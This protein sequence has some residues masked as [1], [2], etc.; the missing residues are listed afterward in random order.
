MAEQLPVLVPFVRVAGR[1]EGRG[2]CTVSV[3]F[4]AF[5]DI[6]RYT[7]ILECRLQ[8]AAHLR[9]GDVRQASLV[10]A[11]EGDGRLEGYQGQGLSRNLM[12]I[13]LLV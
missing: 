12:G 11:L 2:V 1:Y 5:P 10:G 8:Q 6:S 7:C 9:V 4:V 3:D 13:N